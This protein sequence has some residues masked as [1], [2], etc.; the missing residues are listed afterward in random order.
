MRQVLI[1]VFVVVL[2]GPMS[3][4][5]PEGPQGPAGPPRPSLIWTIGAVGRSRAWEP[6]S[7][8][9][10]TVWNAPEIPDVD[11]N[12]RRVPF[13]LR[14]EWLWFRDEDF[15]IAAGDSAVLTIAYTKIDGVAGTAEAHISIPG[16]FEITSHDTST[17]VEIP[18][19]T[20]LTVNWSS[21][22]GAD[23]YS[24]Y[25]YFYYDYLD[26]LGNWKN[27]TCTVDT[28]LTA[29]SVT[30]APSGLFPNAGEID[31]VEWSGGYFHVSAAQGPWEEGAEG[32][33]TGDGMGFF[34]GWTFGGMLG[35]G[36]SSS[37]LLSNGQ[38]E[39][40]NHIQEFL[41]RKA[42]QLSP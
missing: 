12:D 21:S 38:D 35:L 22:S 39:G 42:S 26:T 18:V 17:L 14:R 30:F 1:A 40:R 10:V 25:L 16:Q 31:T 15:P 23:V 20:G 13:Y 34:Y 6:G 5:G 24:A 29:T 28:L 9:S 36:V 33:V 32:N 8:A 27:Y 11:V 41:E 37:D 19:G 7:D 3:C 4:T 2:G